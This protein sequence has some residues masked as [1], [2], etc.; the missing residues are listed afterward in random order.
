MRLPQTRNRRAAADAERR[1]VL[2][3]ANL[4]SSFGQL[5]AL[6]RQVVQAQAEAHEELRQLRQGQVEARKRDEA[7][8]LRMLQ[9]EEAEAMRQS[10]ASLQMDAPPAAAAGHNGVQ[11]SSR[12]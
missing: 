4:E 8:A 12:H 9:L 10:Q 2:E 5:A 7:L 1:V 3:M 6:L 11:G